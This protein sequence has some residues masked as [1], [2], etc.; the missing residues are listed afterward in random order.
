MEAG[1]KQNL[2]NFFKLSTKENK[3]YL[4]SGWGALRL[5]ATAD[6]PQNTLHLTGGAFLW[7][8]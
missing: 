7:N 3:H 2:K 6:H 8:E 5:A 4:S 1:K